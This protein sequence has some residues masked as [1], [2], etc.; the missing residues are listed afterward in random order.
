MCS[1]FKGRLRKS[2]IQPTYSTHLIYLRAYKTSLHV[3]FMHT[4]T[5][6]SHHARSHDDMLCPLKG[7]TSNDMKEPHHWS[8]RPG[9]S[10][11]VITQTNDWLC[12]HAA[13]ARWA[14]WCRPS[15]TATSPTAHMQNGSMKQASLK[16]NESACGLQPP[17]DLFWA[18]GGIDERGGRRKMKFIC[19]QCERASQIWVWGAKAEISSAHM[20]LAF[21]WCPGLLHLCLRGENH[22]SEL[23]NPFKKSGKDG[24]R[25]GEELCIRGWRFWEEVDGLRRSERH[26]AAFVGEHEIHFWVSS[27]EVVTYHLISHQL[28]T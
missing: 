6:F 14:L 5:F 1:G 18:R 17:L 15:N 27:R 12:V 28:F 16:V 4:L 9:K 8:R 25:D 3:V 2:I 11:A 20:E 10:A 7:W 24:A 19:T 23:L 21:Q 26:R 22:C 13:A